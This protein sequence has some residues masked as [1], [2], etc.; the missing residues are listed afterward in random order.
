MKSFPPTPTAEDAPE[1]FESGHL[2]L[3]ERVDGAPLRVQLQS[4]GLLR[5]GDGDR[6]YD[7]ADELPLSVQHAVRH[8]QEHLDRDALRAA[9]DDPESVVLLGVATRY[10]G[11]DYDWERLPAFLGVDVWP[12]SESG[13]RPPD[14]GQAIFERLGLQ[15]VN[16]F[17]RERR[18]RDFDP[19]DYEM[20]TSNWYDGPAAG[21]LVR[22]KRGGRAVLRNSEVEQEPAPLNLPAEELAAAYATSERFESVATT[23]RERD[24]TVTVE[25]LCER[26]VEEIVREEYARLD[27]G[28]EQ[29]D[30]SAFTSAVARRARQHLGSG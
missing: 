24:W 25:T 2:W 4:S 9:V 22:N 8:I 13:F 29:L 14:A 16:T 10:E 26:V 28:R 18:A 20:P 23:L 3:L 7:D 11:V 6:A 15:P 1:L 27:A 19:G 30:E 21:V 5:F 12:G 17:E